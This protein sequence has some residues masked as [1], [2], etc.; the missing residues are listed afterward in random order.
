MASL[1]LFYNVNYFINVCSLSLLF[2]A[3]N[4]KRVSNKYEITA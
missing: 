2:P 3:V 4:K 1:N